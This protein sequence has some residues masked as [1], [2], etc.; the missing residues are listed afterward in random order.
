MISL[1]DPLFLLVG[2]IFLPLFISKKAAFLGYSQLHLMDSYRGSGFLRHLPQFL[3]ALTIVLLVIG[4]ARPQKSNVVAYERF[5]ARDII[6]V[7]DLSYSM[8][9]TFD[10]KGGPRKIDVA[11]KA[12]L[13]FIQKRENDRIGLLVF[14]DNTFGSWPLTRDL[15][16]I[17]KKVSR[18]GSTF[19]GGTDLAQPFLKALAH[20]REMGQS[21]SRVLVYLSDGKGRI[22]EKLKERIITEMKKTDTHLYLL[23]INIS[24]E[25]ND[26]LEIVERTDGRFFV[27]DSAVELGKAFEAIDRLE[28][29]MVEIEVQGEV[30]EMYFQT[31][32]LALGL[33]LIWTLLRHTLY[34]ELS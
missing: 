1:A 6:L 23:G 11:K 34:I 12:A 18:L 26:L 22:P 15:A 30:R 8:E 10:T 25:K 32:F 20:F 14:G 31:V 28:P 19:Y 17:L 2:F 16:L 33:M 9:D 13:Q 29:S 7:V 4:L 21:E 5:L 3:F 27:A 24:K